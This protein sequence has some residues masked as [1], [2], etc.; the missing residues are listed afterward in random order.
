MRI[1][2]DIVTILLLL[3]PIFVMGQS[4]IKGVVHDE[5]G[6]SLAFANVVLKHIN[7]STKIVKGTTT[8]LK[9]NYVFSDVLNGRYIEDVAYVGYQSQFDTIIIKDKNISKNFSLKRLVTSLREVEVKSSSVENGI[10]KVT[11]YTTHNDIKNA[12]NSFTLL[13]KIP[14]LIVNNINN[15]ITTVKGS[16]VKILING[17]NSNETDLLA[18]KPNQV[19]KIEYYNMPPARYANL[20]FAAVINVITKKAQQGI[21]GVVNLKNAVTRS[22]GND[23]LDIKYNSKNAQ[24]GLS[25]YLSY[26]DLY[27]K[28][29]DEILQYEINGLKYQKI[30]TGIK[31]PM[32]YLQNK[33]ELHYL[34]Q[35]DSSYSFRI[36]LTPYYMPSSKDNN[37]LLR[38]TYSGVGKKT[39][40]KTGVGNTIDNSNDYRCALDV[41]YDRNLKKNQKLIFDIVST[42]FNT[43]YR[44]L[45]NE[46]LNGN[47]TILY[48]DN[49]TKSNK[50]STIGEGLFKKHF[51]HFNVNFG[52]RLSFSHSKQTVNNMFGEKYFSIKTSEQYAY[53]EFMGKIK[54]LS[55]D[56]SI[57][58]SLNSYSENEN[59]SQYSFFI[60]RPSINIGYPITKKS[61]FTLTYSREP[62]IPDISLLSSNKFLIDQ[63]I[64]YAGNPNLKPYASNDIDLKYSLQ[65]PRL[66]F[67]T[68]VEYYYAKNTIFANFIQKGTAIYYIPENQ[69]WE[70]GFYW[71]ANVNYTPFKSGIVNLSLNA[72][73]YKQ[74]QKTNINNKNQID[75]FAFSGTIKFNYKNFHLQGQYSP[76]Y[77]SISDQYI[78]TTQPYSYIGGFYKKQNIEIGCGL[79]FPFS[80]SWHISD[81]TFNNSLVHDRD[82]VNIYDLGNMFILNFSYNFS[83]GR[84]Y[85]AEQKMIQ[86]S[87]NQSGVLKVK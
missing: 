41:Y 5:K 78:S 1:R 30:K 46:V 64:I 18:I 24:Y 9:G 42:Y 29:V 2:K 19:V 13:E 72:G 65:L 10:N 84:K 15:T 67:S 60:L 76:S 27:K 49:I 40:E 62:S 73:Y 17:M 44:N 8:D 33:F 66:Y 39:E 23:L 22:F 20:G 47:D 32:K 31:S 21:S 69:K 16:K 57:G 14:K 51:A 86:N 37:Q 11:F 75:G 59:N 54:K 83:S 80:K 26:R 52:L 6:K 53:S 25:Y 74:A 82:A 7:D 61:S 50:I 70:N 12:N 55:Y 3:V 71:D 28:T 43:R 85:K 63:N 38:Y 48:D 68:D 87:D 36:K 45:E 35:K 77:Y 56:L 58:I 79:L 34:Y 4:Q 81:R